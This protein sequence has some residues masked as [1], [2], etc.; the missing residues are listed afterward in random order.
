MLVVHTTDRAHAHARTRTPA[1]SEFLL[2]VTPTNFR[3][4]A[5]LA[6]AQRAR[7][8]AKTNRGV[9]GFAHSAPGDISPG[10]GQTPLRRGD[11]AAQRA[12][13]R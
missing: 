12:G 5:R 9:C 8:Y 1:P 4:L 7:A 3:R 2:G 11:F 13:A 10:A 6:R